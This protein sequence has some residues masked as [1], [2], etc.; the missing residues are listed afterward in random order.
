MIVN[1]SWIHDYEFE[2]AMN[3]RD[4]ESKLPWI[5]WLWI[6]RRHE[7]RDYESENTL[8]SVSRN[9]K[10]PWIRTYESSKSMNLKKKFLMI[11][12]FP[13]VRISPPSYSI[14][15]LLKSAIMSLRVGEGG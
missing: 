14:H 12:E 9:L 2:N 5:P 10:C 6:W 3:F 15:D 11:H 13:A 7:L 4:Y 1:G 8:N